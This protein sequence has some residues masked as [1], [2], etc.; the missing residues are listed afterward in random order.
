MAERVEV[1]VMMIWSLPVCIEF[2][3]MFADGQRTPR[4]K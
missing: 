3:I 4:E 2:D 1:E